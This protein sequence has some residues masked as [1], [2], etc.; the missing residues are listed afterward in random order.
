LLIE[1][2]VKEEREREKREREGGEREE[3]ERE[4]NRERERE[5]ERERPFKMIMPLSDVTVQPNF[6][7]V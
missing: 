6:K 4:G 7:K 1:W 3:G 5:G 2:L